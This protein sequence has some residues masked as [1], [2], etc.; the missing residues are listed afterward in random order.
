[1]EV[2]ILV[3]GRCCLVESEERDWWLSAGR[4]EVRFSGTHPNGLESDRLKQGGSHFSPRVV[5][6]GTLK[7]LS[8]RSS[9]D[10]L[11]CEGVWWEQNRLALSFNLLPCPLNGHY[12]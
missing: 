1:M 10:H 6:C 12:L 5:G 9:I 4:I 3:T 11:R 7:V 2:E 8:A